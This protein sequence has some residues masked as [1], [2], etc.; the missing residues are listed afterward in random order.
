M[1]KV[2]NAIGL[3]FKGGVVANWER[4]FVAITGLVDSDF[5]FLFR[6]QVPMAVE[7]KMWCVE[8]RGD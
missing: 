4:T 3:R 8:C 2:Q 7:T 1:R 5:N 6:S